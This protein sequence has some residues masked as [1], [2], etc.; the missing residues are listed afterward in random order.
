MGRPVA[1]ITGASSGIGAELAKLSAADGHDLVLVASSRDELQARADEL[2]QRYGNSVRVLPKDLSEPN[3]AQAIF[4]ELQGAGIAV[5]ILINNAGFAIYGLFWRNDTRLTLDMLRVNVVALA[6]LTRLILPQMVERA[7]GRVLNV[8]STA[9]FQPGPLMAA[10]YASKAY[11]LSFSEAVA[12][13]LKGTGVT[14]TVLCPGPTRTRFEQRAGLDLSRLSKWVPVSDAQTVAR[15]GYQA[16]MQGKTIV[17]P[18]L[19]NRVVAFSARLAPRRVVTAIAR[20]LQER[21]A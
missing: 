6:H 17:I 21:V 18:G 20:A 1:L 4:D 10:Y 13:E 8:A 3:A 15:A 2:T 5:E 14:M 19:L 9:A 16:M 11:V 12:N 7:H